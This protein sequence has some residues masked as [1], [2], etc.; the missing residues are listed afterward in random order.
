MK[1]NKQK[2]EMIDETDEVM[3]KEFRAE[4]SSDAVRESQGGW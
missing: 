2:R 1:F 4:M 3:D